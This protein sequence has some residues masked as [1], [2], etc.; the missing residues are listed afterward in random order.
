MVKVGAAPA[1]V[2]QCDVRGYL[3]DPTFLLEPLL[4]GA[5]AVHWLCE[6]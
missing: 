3:T 6:Q 4:L 2:V 5:A 1:R